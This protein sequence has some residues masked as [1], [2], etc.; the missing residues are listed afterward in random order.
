MSADRRGVGRVRAAHWLR[1]WV[2]GA[3]AAMSGLCRQ[4]GSPGQT[5]V[6]HSLLVGTNV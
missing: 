6:D 4:A 5:P 1:E 3:G 2:V